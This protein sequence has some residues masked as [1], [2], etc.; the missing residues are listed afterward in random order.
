MSI[1]LPNLRAPALFGFLITLPF[2]ILEIVNQKAN[3]GFPTRL[4]GVL[5]LSSTLFFAT[6]HPILHSLRA[7]GKLFDHLFSLFVRLI[8]LFMLAAMW[9][10]AISD[11]MP[12]F[13]GVPNCD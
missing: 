8:V 4:F 6:L 2:A 13:L 3:P 10:G 9:F 5:W 1:C 7:G 11:Q 12:C